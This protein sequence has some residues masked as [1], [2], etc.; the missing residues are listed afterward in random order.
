MHYNSASPFTLSPLQ[1]RAGMLSPTGRSKTL[2]ASA[3]GYV[4]GEAVGALILQVADGGGARGSALL[5]ATVN[6]DGRSS[7]SLMAPNGPAQYQL[8]RAALLEANVLPAELV[9]VQLHGT[10]TALG[11]PIEVGAVSSVLLARSV[12]RPRALELQA[13]KPATG[14]GE[15]AAGLTGLLGMCLLLSHGAA[16]PVLHLRSVNP[17]VTDVLRTGGTGSANGSRIL[18]GLAP[19]PSTPGT[20]TVMAN[21]FAWHGTNANV[22]TAIDDG[23]V[24]PVSTPHRSLQHLRRF[25]VVARV[26]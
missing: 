6:Q 7:A 14:H 18:R 2:D 9:G 17:H 13:N 11:D 23:A 5:A 16:V 4:R 24:L 19:A 20:P 12:Q 15:P 22:V 3:D 21:A 10:G 26:R 8:M 25:S 1:Q